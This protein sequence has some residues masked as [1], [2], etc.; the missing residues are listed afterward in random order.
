MAYWKQ[1]SL[2]TMRTQVQSLASL[3]ELR[4]SIAMSSGVGHRCGLDLAFL[5]LWCRPAAAAP[6]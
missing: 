3:S 5:W 6:I 2:V 1:I 4:I